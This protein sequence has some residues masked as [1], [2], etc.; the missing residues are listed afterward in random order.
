MTKKTLPI[1]LVGLF[2]LILP[3]TTLAQTDG[4]PLQKDVFLGEPIL[5]PEDLPDEVTFNL[6]DSETALN[7]IATQTFPKGEYTVD[8]EFS[9]SDGL[10]SGY[11][12]RIKADLCYVTHSY[13]R[14]PPNL[15]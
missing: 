1:I 3:L 9:K 7:P 8:F 11:V 4:I 14:Y 10:T 2:T 6:Y 15:Y 13:I 12:S 5:G